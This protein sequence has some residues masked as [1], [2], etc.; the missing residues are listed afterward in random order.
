MSVCEPEGRVSG[1]IRAKQRCSDKK[2]PFSRHP[3]TALP[4]HAQRGNGQPI[5]GSLAANAI[6][7][8][9]PEGDYFLTTLR[10]EKIYRSRMTA[11]GT[12]FNII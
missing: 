10:V 7:E 3:R 1:M 8:E 4:V 2:T 11:E 12:R 5:R 6:L 9:I